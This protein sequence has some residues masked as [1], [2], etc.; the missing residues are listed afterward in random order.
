MNT[1]RKCAN[2]IICN[3]TI[4]NN[5]DKEIC[6]QCWLLFTKVKIDNSNN[7][8]TNNG[9][10]VHYNSTICNKCDNYRRCFKCPYCNHKLCINCF[11]N[12]YFYKFSDPPEFPYPNEYDTYFE[13]STDDKW[14]NDKLIQ[15]FNNEFI[16][17]ENKI[18]L[19]R[20]NH[21]RLKCCS[22]C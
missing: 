16:E 11:N 14:V 6:F 1:N 17:Y 13:N 5:S 4:N 3:T 12:A 10:L 18:K 8:K 15:K 20:E 19:E 22:F 7:I 2:Y 21:S 9:K